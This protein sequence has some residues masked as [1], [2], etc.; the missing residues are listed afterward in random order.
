M[1]YDEIVI[2]RNMPNQREHLVVTTVLQQWLI[3]N[4]KVLDLATNELLYYKDPTQ[5]RLLISIL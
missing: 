5:E 2:E 4:E 1:K 3:S